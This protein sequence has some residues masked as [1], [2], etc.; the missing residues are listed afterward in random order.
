MKIISM[1]EFVLEQLVLLKNGEI[2]ILQFRNRIEKY[3]NFLKKILT[4]GM[5]VPCDLDGNVIKEYDWV[6]PDSVKWEDYEKELLEAKSR[7]LFDGFRL[8]NKHLWNKDKLFMISD[9]YNE[10]FSNIKTIEWLISITHEFE[11][12]ESAKKQIGL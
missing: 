2:N 4:L 9:D 10:S 5:F 8:E 3:A 6:S 11:L 7:V 12:T 1:V